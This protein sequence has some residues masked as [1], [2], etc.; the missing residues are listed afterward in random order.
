[1]SDNKTIISLEELY[2]EYTRILEAAANNELSEVHKH[3]ALA[4][5]ELKAKDSKIIFIAPE[6]NHKSKDFLP[7]DGVPVELYDNDV[8]SS[9]EYITI[10]DSDDSSEM[11]TPE[12][13]PD[14]MSEEITEETSNSASKV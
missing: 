9:S 4:Y 3:G 13:I 6:L 11:V 7:L 2:K 14:P 1:M 5:L 12:P 8:E 10:S